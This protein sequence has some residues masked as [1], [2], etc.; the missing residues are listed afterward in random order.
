M[1]QTVHPLLQQPQGRQLEFKRDLSS[2]RNL[3]KTLVAF[4]NSAGGRLVI[5]VDDAQQI[6]G[7]A[8]PLAEEERV[9]NLIADGIAPRLIPDVEI[10]SVGSAPL[11][12]IAVYPSSGRPHHVKALG[13]QQGTYLRLGSSNRQ[14]GP[15][16]IAQ[17]H[18]SAAGLVFDEQPMA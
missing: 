1:K 10:I 5:G 12:V 16:W 15:D 11:L 6:V 7:V 17:A 14:A 18:R 9:C 13:E 4:A 8:D 2:T 3:L